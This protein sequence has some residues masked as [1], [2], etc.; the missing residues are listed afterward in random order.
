MGLSTCPRAFSITSR[1]GVSGSSSARRSTF[2]TTI[3]AASTT[4]PMARIRPNMEMIVTLMP[5]NLKTANVP[6]RDTGMVTTVIIVV[7]QLC[8]K[9]SDTVETINTASIR[10]SITPARAAEIKAV[11]S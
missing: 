5:A 2:S 4:I 10:V 7:R 11:V 6:I 9:N 1:M 8:R 3:M